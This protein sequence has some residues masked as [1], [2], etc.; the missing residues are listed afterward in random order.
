MQEANTISVTAYTPTGFKVFLCYQSKGP[1]DAMGVVEKLV[2][3]GFVPRE[4]GVE[5]GQQD[6]VFDLGCVVRREYYNDKNELKRCVDLYQNFRGKAGVYAR[7]QFWI[8]DEKSIAEFYA[9]TGVDYYKMKIREENTALTR[10]PDRKHPCEVTPLKECKFTRVEN[11][12]YKDKQSGEEKT[13]YKFDKWIPLGGAVPQNESSSPADSVELVREG[14][15]SILGEKKNDPQAANAV[16]LYLSGGSIGMSDW[17]NSAT[18]QK[19]AATLF[20][21]MEQAIERHGNRILELATE[22]KDVPF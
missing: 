17:L 5:P 10:N 7:E 3:S 1:E 12:T 8:N 14:L 11:G 9:V 2:Q 4:P 13:R 18:Q 19:H 22:V 15:K 20:P 21:L 6:N 16:L